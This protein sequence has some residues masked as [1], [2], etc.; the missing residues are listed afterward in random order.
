MR[1]AAIIIKRATAAHVHARAQ[2]RERTGNPGDFHFL[3]FIGPLKVTF[4]PP[5]MPD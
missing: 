4:A 5:F 2:T 3:L 1:R